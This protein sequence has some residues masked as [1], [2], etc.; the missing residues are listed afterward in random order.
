MYLLIFCSEKPKK[1]LVNSKFLISDLQITFWFL[2]FRHLPFFGLFKSKFV[3]K[4]FHET[5][6]SD[7]TF[8]RILKLTNSMCIQVLWINKIQKNF[9][10]FKEALDLKFQNDSMLQLYLK[11]KISSIFDKLSLYQIFCHFAFCKKSC[12]KDTIFCRMSSRVWPKPSVFG[13]YFFW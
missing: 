11:H 1:Q 3:F 5:V 2:V 8:K 4:G 6:N 7:V 13:F 9:S 10:N 12:D